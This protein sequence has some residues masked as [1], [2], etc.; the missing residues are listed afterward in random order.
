MRRTWRK[1]PRG[2]HAS[3]SSDTDSRREST[4]REPRRQLRAGTKLPVVFMGDF[5]DRREIFYCKMR[6][7][8]QYSSSVWWQLQDP[9]TCTLPRRA[10]IDW[11]FGSP[12]LSFT[13]YLKLDGGLV[14]EAS[15]H[16]LIVSRV[17]R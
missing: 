11:I 7:K 8:E 13:G 4:E 14:D 3:R 16:P 15:D 12:D 5:N 9:S 6:S 2:K 1:R 17:L 10:G